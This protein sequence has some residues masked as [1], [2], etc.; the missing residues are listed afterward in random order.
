M[1]ALQSPDLAADPLAAPYVK[2]ELVRV[3][4]AKQAGALISLEGP[5]HYAAGDALI[6]GATGERWSVA[7]DRFDAKYLPEPPLAAGSDG[8]YR[9]RPVPVLAKQM[10]QPFTLARKSGGDVLTGAAR[11]WVLQYGPGDYGVI[12]NQRFMRVYRSYLRHLP[13]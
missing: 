6:S 7:R 8:P 2:D 1:L 5:N 12:A 3:V 13:A 10:D 9:S 11:D 4:F